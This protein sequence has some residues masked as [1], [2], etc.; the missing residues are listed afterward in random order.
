MIQ[1]Q[2]QAA[3]AAAAA[4]A[5]GGGGANGGVHAAAS[6][7]RKRGAIEI[8]KQLG[9]MGLYKGTSACL[10]RDIPFSGIYFT[11]YSHLK[12]DYF[13]ESDT[14]RLGMG[15]LLMAGAI[16][17]MPAAYLTT[18][19]DVIKTR[20]VSRLRSG[21]GAFPHH[22]SHRAPHRALHA[23]RVVLANLLCAEP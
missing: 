21:G 1:V 8:V 22:A 7:A 12:K 19:A 20:S 4:A 13:G 9:L 16:A 18:P 6:A 10:L 15:E 14:K 11:A 3:A 17:G 5:S 23:P 2:G